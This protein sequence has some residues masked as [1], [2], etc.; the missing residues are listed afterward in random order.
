[1]QKGAFPPKESDRSL[2]TVNDNEFPSPLEEL[3][4][5]HLHPEGISISTREPGKAGRKRH[6]RKRL[7]PTSQ[8]NC[9]QVGVEVELGTREL[10]EQILIVPDGSMKSKLRTNKSHLHSC[11]SNSTIC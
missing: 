7:K 5:K 4:L 3:A 8:S 6:L 9:T 1:M 2:S 11:V 10:Q